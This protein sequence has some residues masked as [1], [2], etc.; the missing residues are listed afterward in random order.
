MLA[1]VVALP[2]SLGSG[3]VMAHPTAHL[4]DAHGGATQTIDPSA[5]RVWW[6]GLWLIAGVG[7]LGGATRPARRRTIALGL[8]LAL[9]VLAL[10]SAVH[11]V[12]HLTSPETAA[13]CPVFSSTEHLGWGETP[14]VASNGPPPHVTPAP[15]LASEDSEGALTHRPRPGRAP[16]A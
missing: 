11:S 15:A 12:H 9:G 13:T 2:L 14:M 5:G 8:S 4:V 3:A 16:P 1:L 7:L 10:E 6:A